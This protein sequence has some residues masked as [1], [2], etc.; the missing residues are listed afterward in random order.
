LFDSLKCES[1]GPSPPIGQAI[2]VDTTTVENL[3]DI[4]ADFQIA[5]PRTFD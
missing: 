5:L 3:A 4:V 2:F 1:I